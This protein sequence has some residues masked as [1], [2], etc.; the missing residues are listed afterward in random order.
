MKWV[1]RNS[2]D[3]CH[4]KSQEYPFRSFQ[5]TGRGLGGEG[6]FHLTEN[7]IFLSYGE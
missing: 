4:T 1:D 5:E 6:V 2:L 3:Y 7:M